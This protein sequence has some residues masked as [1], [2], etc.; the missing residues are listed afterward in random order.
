MEV[1]P[2]PTDQP[3]ADA[4]TSTLE[5]CPHLLN[6]MKCFSNIIVLA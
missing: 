2:A 3:T 4:G 1:D 5:I 6:T